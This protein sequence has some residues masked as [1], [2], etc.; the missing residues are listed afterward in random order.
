MMRLHLPAARPLA[1]LTLRLGLQALW[2]RLTA[3]PAPETLLARQQH[4]AALR[5][6]YDA[7]RSLY[8][9]ASCRSAAWFPRGDCP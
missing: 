7:R 6:E 3:A 9:A 1:P 4:R 5:A 2:A 8:L